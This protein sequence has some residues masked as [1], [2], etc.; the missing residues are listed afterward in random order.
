MH[1]FGRRIRAREAAFFALVAC[2]GPA[3]TVVAGT[4]ADTRPPPPP[5]P[6]PEDAIATT[7]GPPPKVDHQPK[8]VDF[9]LA[10]CGGAAPEARTLQLT[11]SGLLRLKWSA[12]VDSE[13]FA[14]ES[15]TS[16][17]ISVGATQGLSVLAQPV[18]SDADP[19]APITGTLVI[20]L[21]DSLRLGSVAIP[22]KVTPAGAKVVLAPSSVGFGVVALGQTKSVDVG[23][24]NVGNQAV[25]VL[26]SQPAD[27]DMTFEWTG[28]PSPVALGPDAA[29]PGAIVRF[30]PSDAGVH[31]SKLGV[32]LG[33][34][35][36]GAGTLDLPLTG[37][38][39]ADAGVSDAAIS[40]TAISDGATSDGAISDA[41][42][43]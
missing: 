22:L 18:G 11:N 19:G 20:E 6:P 38:V 32:T 7:D 39:A 28:Q 25:N 13:R 5:P 42:G 21:D 36:C 1:V 37:G 29:V 14:L 27:P 4:D 31:T 33:A 17:Q 26:F 40:D 12:R 8:V 3:A 16:G 15:P 23:I 41:T 43:N 30:R 35:A 34:G 10:A 9:G 24:R 2:S